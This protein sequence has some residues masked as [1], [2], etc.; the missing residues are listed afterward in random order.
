M[1]RIKY[2]NIDLLLLYFNGGVANNFRKYE[3]VF[4]F[5]FETHRFQ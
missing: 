1:K 3:Q 4:F 5:I 2:S